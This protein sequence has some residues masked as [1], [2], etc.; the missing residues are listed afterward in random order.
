MTE[1]TLNTRKLRNAMRV[2]PTAVGRGAKT[3]LTDI[4]DDWVRGAVDIA[5]LDK[6]ALRQSISGVVINPGMSG[7]VE[8]EANATQDTGGRR[9][10]Y[11]YYIHEE[12]AGGRTLKLAGA[13]KKFLDEAMKR[14]KDEYQR[15]L[16][17]EINEELRRAGW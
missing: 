8:I 13:E 5:P 10:N 3:A 4:K 17:E 14:R 1:F 2:A 11:A 15:W 7:I 12:N 6:T 9:F 16:I